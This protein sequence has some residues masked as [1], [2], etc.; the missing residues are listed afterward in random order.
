MQENKNSSNSYGKNE[1]NENGW[2]VRFTLGIKN[3]S[4]LYTFTGRGYKLKTPFTNFL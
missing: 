3:K 1:H 4:T 2:S